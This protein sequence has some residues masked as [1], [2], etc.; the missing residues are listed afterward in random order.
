MVLGCEFSCPVSHLEVLSC[1]HLQFYLKSP[2]RASPG[3]FH[4]TPGVASPS[5]LTCLVLWFLDNTTFTESAPF[6]E[7]FQ[8]IVLK[9]NLLMILQWL[10]GVGMHKA[11]QL[12]HLVAPSG[13][14]PA[15]L[16]SL[17]ICSLVS[18][19]VLLWGIRGNF[20][21]FLYNVQTQGWSFMDSHHRP[22]N[23]DVNEF[24]AI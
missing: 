22:R 14:R 24:L 23:T 16:P 18:N 7:L 5:L 15:D 6:Q 13:S 4:L 20:L 12:S 2:P 10:Q 17:R 3:T 1:G 9:R 11:P 19:A 8:G 21:F